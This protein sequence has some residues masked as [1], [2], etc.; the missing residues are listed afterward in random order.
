MSETR[1]LAVAVPEDTIEQ[2]SD[3]NGLKRRHSEVS[4]Q[5]SKRRRTSPGKN[6]PTATEDTAHSEQRQQAEKDTSANIEST[7]KPATIENPPT[8]RGPR[9][10]AG[11]PDEKQR[12]KRLFGALLGNLNQPGGEKTSKRRAEIEQRRKA[13]LQKQDDE[14]IED[15]QRRLEHLAIQR[16]KEQIRVDEENMHIRHQHLLHTANCLQTK[17][18]PPLYYRPWDL[19]PDEE[20]RIDDQLKEARERVDRELAEFEEE[21]RRRLG[22]KRAE[23]APGRAHSATPEVDA[24]KPP[25]AVDEQVQNGDTD[26]DLSNGSANDESVAKEAETSQLDSAAPAEAEEST[27]DIHSGKADEVEEGKVQG[28]EKK[29]EEVEEDGEHVVEGDED[30]VVY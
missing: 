14:R 5:E 15:R 13:E 6:S 30:T 3:T 1:S 20:D 16:K 17:A 24:E 23:E 26:Q 11:V 4:E 27:E 10:R 12:S 22:D 28:E 8:A 2:A 25:E 7:T 19:L 9:R 21:K 18:E 29:E